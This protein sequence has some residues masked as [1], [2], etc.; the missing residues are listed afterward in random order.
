VAL[1]APLG[2]EPVLEVCPLGP[3]AG[4]PEFIG[5]GRDLLSAGP[6]G[7]I[8]PFPSGAGDGAEAGGRCSCLLL[9]MF[10]LLMA[11]SLRGSLRRSSGTVHAGESLAGNDS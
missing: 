10:F 11:H 6:R 4:L 9:T 2:P 1:Q 7:L 5:E 3:A 8:L